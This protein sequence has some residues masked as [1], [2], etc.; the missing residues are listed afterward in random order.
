MSNKPKAAKAAL[1][2]KATP[3]GVA[4]RPPEDWAN[5]VKVFR[6]AAFAVW[7][8]LAVWEQEATNTGGPLL[9][10][11]VASDGKPRSWTYSKWFVLQANVE[12]DTVAQVL[13]INDVELSDP[14]VQ[15]LLRV[16]KRACERAEADVLAAF[17]GVR[18]T[19]RREF[20]KRVKAS[21]VDEAVRSGKPRHEAFQEMGISHSSAYRAMGRRKPKR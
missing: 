4:E 9:G 1:A 5:A 15:H 18:V 10:R 11:P 19:G 14:R 16:V 17:G 20:M 12:I 21:L 13:E 6:G 7:N 2:E 8:D 3:G